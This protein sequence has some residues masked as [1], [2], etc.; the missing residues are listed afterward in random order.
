MASGLV[1]WSRTPILLTSMI[2][3]AEALAERFSWVRNG[4]KRNIAGRIADVDVCPFYIGYTD[5]RE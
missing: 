1:V 3:G 5:K 2:T 4:L